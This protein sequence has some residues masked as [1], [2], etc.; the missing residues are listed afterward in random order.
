MSGN[1][2]F[3]DK[4]CRPAPRP[5]ATNWPLLVL[6]GIVVLLG[7]LA[8]W[9]WSHQQPSGPAQPGTGAPA[10]NRSEPERAQ[11]RAGA[12][13]DNA[14]AELGKAQSGAGA[15]AD[16]LFDVDK[17]LAGAV[18]P[19]DNRSELAKAQP[20]PVT[21]ADIRFDLEKASVQVF[22]NTS[23]SVVHVTNVTER[24][25]PTTL[26]LEDIPRETGTGF[27]WDDQGHIVTN[28]HVVEKA[29]LLRVVFQDGSSYETRDVWSYPDKDIAVLNVK[30]PKSQLVTIPV[31]TSH[32]LQVGQLAFAIGNPFGLDHSLS[33]GV[34]SAMGREIATPTKRQLHGLIQTTAAI[35]PGN[36][37]GPLLDSA[38]RLIGMNTAM[39]SK[40]GMFG[41]IGFAIPVDE[42]NR[43]VPQLITHGK[44]VRPHLAVQVA[45]DQQARLLGVKEGALLL[46]VPSGSLA[47]QAGLRGAHTDAGRS[48]LGDVIV[49]IDDKP[50]KTGKDLFVVLEQYKL[51]DAVTIGFV[52]DGQKKEAK[53]TLEVTE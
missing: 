22:K 51:G 37:G 46:R 41:G 24:R 10:D 42:I 5:A 9:V 25:N 8:L 38:G 2:P 45:V 36:S 6:L 31:G 33:V 44:V 13:G 4:P 20:G 43:V 28:Y 47:E 17:P 27:V 14:R 50:I 35:N 39:F 1:D 52:R 49:S 12:P 16:N 29:N 34:V 48:V 30:A 15:P 19:A 40:S 53:A 3:Y 21:P 32:D 26:N 11:P 7:G 18:T 23:A